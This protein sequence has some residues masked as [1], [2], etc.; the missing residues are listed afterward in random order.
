MG[1][2]TEHLP[3]DSQFFGKHVGRLSIQ[4]NNELDRALR[5]SHK[6]N[7]EIVYIYSPAAI[8]RTSIGQFSLSD[9]GGQI[10]FTKDLSNFKSYKPSHIPEI[11]EYRSDTPSPELLELAYLSGHL[12]RFRVDPLLPI[13]SFK[14]LYE[15][16]ITKTIK[17]RP[18]TAIYTYQL[19]CKAAGFATVSWNDLKCTI[20]LL[21]VLKTHQGHGIATKLI[22]HITGICVNNNVNT[23]EVKTQLS[24][25]VARALYLKNSFTELD[26]SY[27][28]HAHNLKQAISQQSHIN[29][30]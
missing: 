29:R 27:L 13:E 12:S 23:I 8:G 17:S 22:R 18:R 15:S 19:S 30:A 10:T 6:E 9:V 21:G 14:R 11:D 4:A 3:W 2:S 5:M 16:W 25:A 7:F 26:R 28:Y 1:E 24:N 20:D